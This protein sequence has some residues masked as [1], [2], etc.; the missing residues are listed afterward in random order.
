[1][2]FDTY[3]FNQLSIDQFC[4]IVLILL[5]IICLLLFISVTHQKETK[6]NSEEIKNILNKI[7]DK[8]GTETNSTKEENENRFDT[9]TYM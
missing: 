3:G 5:G 1:M 6:E 2:L 8:K 4:T 7:A 9:I